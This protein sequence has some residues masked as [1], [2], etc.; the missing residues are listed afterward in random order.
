MG[1]AGGDLDLPRT[2]CGTPLR[3]ISGAS[4]LIATER[5]CFKSCARNTV[6]MPPRPS[7]RSI[8]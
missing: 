2:R 4:T 6:A 8:V 3:A 7:S 5:L 1:E